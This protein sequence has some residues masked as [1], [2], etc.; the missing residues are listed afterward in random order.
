[1]TTA[2]SMLSALDRLGIMGAEVPIPVW[3]AMLL[4]AL[5][6]LCL[7][8][9]YSRP[10]LVIAYVFTYRW[11][12]RFCQQGALTV[13]NTFAIVYVLFGTAVLALVAATML[14]GWGSTRRGE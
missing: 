8:F 1:M 13:W 6:T 10:G 5:L 7:L 11:G 9:R 2:A 3:E 4:L 14:F 12:W